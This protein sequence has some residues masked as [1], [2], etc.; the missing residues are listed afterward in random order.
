MALICICVLFP[1]C[2]LLDD[3]YCVCSLQSVPLP[4]VDARKLAV[5]PISPAV[6]LMCTFTFSGATS[7][8]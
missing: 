8:L 1:V 2:F 7:S 4:I 5:C 3:V 6:F